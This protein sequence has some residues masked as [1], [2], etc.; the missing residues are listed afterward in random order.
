MRDGAVVTSSGGSGLGGTGAGAA[1]PAGASAALLSRFS[2]KACLSVASYSSP[3]WRMTLSYLCSLST[4]RRGMG[5]L[6]KW[7]KKRPVAQPP[8]VHVV[9]IYEYL[10]LLM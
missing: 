8:L 6:L 4:T 7:R 3:G 9:G 2:T 1:T 10:P 5:W